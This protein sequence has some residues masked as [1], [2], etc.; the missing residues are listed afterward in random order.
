M[1][2]RIADMQ[3]WRARIERQERLGRLVAAAI[4]LGILALIVGIGRGLI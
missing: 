3:R 4:V 1:P 2:D